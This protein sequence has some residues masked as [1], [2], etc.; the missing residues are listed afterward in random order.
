MEA[1]RIGETIFRRRRE[2]GFSQKQ[3]CEGLCTTMAFSRLENGQQLPSR[4]CL[5][6]ILQ[7]LGLPDNDWYSFYL[8]ENELRL[9]TLR[10][11]IMA[12]GGRSVRMEGGEQ[13]QACSVGLQVSREISKYIK[14]D[15]HI[16]R[17]YIL[18]YQTPIGT[19]NSPWSNEEQLERYMMAIRLTIP[20]FCLDRV[21]RYLYSNIELAIVSDIAVCYA[22]G[23]QRRKAINIY[24]QLID[25]IQFH[26]PYHTYLPLVARNYALYLDME[27]RYEEALEITSLGKE[28]AIR[29]EHYLTLP[30]LTHIEA[31]C[32]YYLGRL[33]ESKE[34]YRRAYHLY[35]AVDEKA[36]LVIL[37]GEAK[38]R[39]GLTF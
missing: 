32:N 34:L 33:D 9:A 30:Y 3:V 31:E 21:D 28:T 14:E 11:K 36:D 6:A 39:L 35:L 15:N 29:R 2:Q 25:T 23:G 13:R 7:R 24:R 12:C 5:V 27:K 38:E 37:K 26:Y 8:T 18:F 10:R 1:I 20:H 16:S 4:D 19:E 22:R 17:Q